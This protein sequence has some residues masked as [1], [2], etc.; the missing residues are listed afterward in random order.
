MEYHAR[1][2]GRHRVAGVTHL[3]VGHGRWAAQAGAAGAG[4]VQALVGALDDE[5][6]DELRQGAKTTRWT[7]PLPFAAG[8]TVLT[9]SPKPPTKVVDAALLPAG[10]ITPEPMRRGR[11]EALRLTADGRAHVGRQVAAAGGRL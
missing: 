9:G 5:F 7:R 10:A 2:R 4:G 8:D 1:R 3:F 6:A 11:P